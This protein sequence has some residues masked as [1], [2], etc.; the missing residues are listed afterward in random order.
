MKANLPPF[1]P[2][3]E[4]AYDLFVGVLLSSDILEAS[5]DMTEMPP[6]TFA[7][8]SPKL[9]SIAWKDLVVGKYAMGWLHLLQ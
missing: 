4:I 6:D 8:I 1:C 7:N 3:L 2:L 5:Q 9:A